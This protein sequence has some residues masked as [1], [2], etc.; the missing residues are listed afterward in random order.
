MVKFSS[1]ILLSPFSSAA[2]LPVRAGAAEQIAEFI[3]AYRQGQRTD[4]FSVVPAQ[5][6]Y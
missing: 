4:D 1:I 3:L 2:F 5:D 6:L